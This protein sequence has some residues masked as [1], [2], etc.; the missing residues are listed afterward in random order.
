M[1]NENKEKTDKVNELQQKLNVFTE[2]KTVSNKEVD[3]LKQ[4]NKELQRLLHE[5]ES[6]IQEINLT[7]EKEV[8]LI[9]I[10]LENIKDE[11]CTEFTN[12]IG[13]GISSSL[14]FSSIKI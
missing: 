6:F 9:K 12:K 8:E 7:K 4:V 5:K 3:T 11:L 14:T 13:Q 10:E 1:Q 2:E